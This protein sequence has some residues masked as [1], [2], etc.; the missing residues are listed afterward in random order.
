MGFSLVAE[1]KGYCLVLMHG[2]LVSV[3]PL[4][5]ELLWSMWALVVVAPRLQGAGSMAV[6]RR[7]NY[8]VASGI[9][10]D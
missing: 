8:F 6:A 1:S 5:A 9:F 3:P 2:R 7:L 10:P 4:V